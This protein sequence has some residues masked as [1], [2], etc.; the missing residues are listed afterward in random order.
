[1]NKKILILIILTCLI[2]LGIGL[3]SGLKSAFSFTSLFSQTSERLSEVSSGT[4]AEKP[5]AETKTSPASDISNSKPRRQAKSP[6]KKQS[7]KLEEACPPACQTRILNLLGTG[8]P[9]TSAD[10]NIIIQTA[11]EFAALLAKSP[12]KLAELLSRLQE[13]EGGKDYDQFAAQAVWD[14]LTDEARAEAGQALLTHLRPEFRILGIKLSGTDV[15]HDLS[16][17]QAFD[18]LIQRETNARVLITALNA[19][20]LKTETGP[21]AATII[22]GLDR[23]ISV[24][25]SDYIKGNA[26]LAKARVAT[27]TYDIAPDIRRA[28]TDSSNKYK[29]HGLRALSV[30]LER[31][32]ALEE[33]STSHWT[34]HQDAEDMLQALIDNPDIGTANR[35]LAAQL[36]DSL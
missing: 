10:S 14:A 27:S 8:A 23:L 3:Y 2:G 25:E 13:D 16:A 12:E 6:R 20:N 18:G 35:N 32:N 15:T 5:L 33:T 34:R 7:R 22:T 17:A 31:R 24:H 21:H 29:G 28:L 11:E 4:A 36:L 30:T 1:M 19:I 26:L 9:L